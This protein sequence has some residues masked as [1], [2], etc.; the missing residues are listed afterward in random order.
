M[1]KQISLLDGP[2]CHVCN[3]SLEL[4][5]SLYHGFVDGDTRQY[6]HHDCKKEHYQ[7]KFTKLPPTYCE[8]PVTPIIHNH[9]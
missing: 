3:N 1:G 4:K 2:K 9:F 8:L 7:I 5:G 6:V